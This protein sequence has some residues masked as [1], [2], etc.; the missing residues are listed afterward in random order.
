MSAVVVQ[1]QNVRPPVVIQKENYPPYSVLMSVYQ[2]E[3]PDWLIMSVESM[4]AQTVSPHDIVMVEDGPLTPELYTA[5]DKLEE[6]YPCLLRVPLEKNVGLGPALAEGVLHCPC[7]LIA[8]I[9]TDDYAYP[10]RCQEQLD[11]MRIQQADMVGSNVNEFIDSLM[12]ITAQR[13]LPETHDQIIQFSKKRTP[14]AHPSVMFKKSIV[15]DAGNYRNQYLVE[16]Y[17]L[18]VRMFQKGAKAY[19]IQKPLVGMRVS[20]EFYLRRGGIPYLKSLLSFNKQLL[21]CGWYTL[22]DYLF[23]SGGNIALALMPNHLRDWTYRRF[24]RK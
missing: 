5:L 24:L 13:I 1:K 4:M 22:K 2:K 11:A 9:D 12:N 15:L 20:E 18:F 23:R 19:N 17:D 8:R 6:T 7:E 14:I 10:T 3:R 16:D 21:H